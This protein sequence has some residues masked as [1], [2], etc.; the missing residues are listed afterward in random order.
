MID[1]ELESNNNNEPDRKS[2]AHNENTIHSSKNVEKQKADCQISFKT[3]HDK[4]DIDSKEINTREGNIKENNMSR[5]KLP[6]HT[7]E[8]EVKIQKGKHEPTIRKKSTMRNMVDMW[9]NIKLDQ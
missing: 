9:D 4:E 6:I 8:Q 2:C 7:R 5:N 3:K 1:N